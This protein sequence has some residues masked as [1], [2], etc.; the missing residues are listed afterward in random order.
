MKRGSKILGTRREVK[1]MNSFRNIEKAINYEFLE[2]CKMLESGEAINQETLLWDDN[3]EVT[4]SIRSKEDAHDYRYF[5]EPDLPPLEISNNLID[6]IK[7]MIPE[8]PRDIRERLLSKFK[9][10]NEEINFL[11]NNRQLLHYYEN[12]CGDEPKNPKKYLN[13]GFLII[14]LYL[15]YS[16]SYETFKIS[17]CFKKL[18]NLYKNYHN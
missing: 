10:N 3:N 15:V 14:L 8:L 6:E 13:E 16:S 1:N 11:I 9:L 12:L 17:F 2:Q 18:H 7:R 5:P 4:K